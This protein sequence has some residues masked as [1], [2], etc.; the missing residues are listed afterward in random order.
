MALLRRNGTHLAHAC[1]GSSTAVRT[2]LPGSQ[3][4]VRSTAVPGHAGDRQPQWRFVPTVLS[5]CNMMM[6]PS[7]LA[8]GVGCAR[9]RLAAARLH[10]ALS[11]RRSESSRMC[12]STRALFAST[13]HF[14]NGSQY[15]V[16]SNRSTCVD[17]RVSLVI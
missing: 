14:T 10:F 15:R 3:I 5:Q 6:R 13:T 2:Q 9:T 1:K 12:R 7:S 4:L 16:G 11:T 17:L 8:G